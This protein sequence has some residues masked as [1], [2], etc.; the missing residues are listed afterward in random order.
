MTVELGDAGEG[1]MLQ[2]HIQPHADGIGG[3]HVID[4][5][6]LI[7]IDLGVARARGEGAE[8]HGTAAARAPHLF[9]QG[10]NIGGGKGDDG[11][12]ARQ[13]RQF[14]RPGIGEGGKA[15]ARRNLDIR[16]QPL[17]QRLHGFGAQEHGFRQ[18]ARVQQPF[19]ENMPALPVGAELDFIDGEEFDPPVKRHGFD[20]ADEPARPRRHDPLFPRHECDGPGTF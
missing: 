16:D 17:D 2:I 11:R 5:A 19:G 18:A 15:R 14:L 10:V 3:D 1:H 4:L 12:P 6:R 9:G 13:A 7:E 20:R 8:H